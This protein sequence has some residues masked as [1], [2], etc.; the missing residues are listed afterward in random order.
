LQ[1]FTLP[2]VGAKASKNGGDVHTPPQEAQALATCK[3]LKKKRKKE[4]KFFTKKMGWLDRSGVRR[5][6]R[7]AT[8][9]RQPPLGRQSYNIFRDF[10]FFH[11]CV[12]HKEEHYDR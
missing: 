12:N 2:S 9:G 7:R 11:T 8:V 4:N 6:G 10:N 1:D 3:G 5:R